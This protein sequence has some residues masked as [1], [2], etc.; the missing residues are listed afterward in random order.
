MLAADTYR[1][2]VWGNGTEMAHHFWW[3]FNNYNGPYTIDGMEPPPH[4]TLAAGPA[5]NID[6]SQVAQQTAAAIQ[7]AIEAINRA[8]GQ[9]QTEATTFGLEGWQVQDALNKFNDLKTKLQALR[10]TV[11]SS[12]ELPSWGEFAITSSS[13]RAALGITITMDAF[14]GI[15][16]AAIYGFALVRLTQDT[17]RIYQ[18]CGTDGLR[19]VMRMVGRGI[20]NT[21]LGGNLLTESIEDMEAIDGC[22][23]WGT[24]PPIN[25]SAVEQ[26]SVEETGSAAAAQAQWIDL[27]Q[28]PGGNNTTTRISLQGANGQYVCAEQGGGAAVVCNRN[29]VGGWETFYEEDLGNGFVALRCEVS[30]WYLCAENGGGGQVSANRQSVGGW[31]SFTRH[32]LG[33]GAVAYQTV[34]GNFL[35]AEGGGGQEIVA[36]RNGI[37]AWETFQRNEF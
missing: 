34:N 25:R 8:I 36:D 6:P 10:Q 13:A 2:T 22:M 26:L 30:G 17:W 28:F 3:F 7:K 12:G 33:G 5:P 32:D 20:A 27:S 18:N 24:R 35:C 9:I 4:M 14:L 11:L 29:G 16:A 1:V 37:G 19:R 21:M 15:I 31:E 23:G